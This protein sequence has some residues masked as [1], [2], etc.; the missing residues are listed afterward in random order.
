MFASLLFLL[1]LQGP[2]DLQVEP[3]AVIAP[4]LIVPAGTVIPVELINRIST[5]NIE[6]GDNVYART[7][8]PITVR[9]QIVIPVG[10]NVLGKIVQVE[11]PGRVKGKASLALTFQ[12]L[13]F[14]NGFNVP[15]YGSLGG[16]DTGN[17]RGESTLEGDSSKGKD[18]GTVAQA[19]APGAIVGGI[20]NGRKGAL[21]G[22]GVGAGVALAGVLLTRGDD[23]D[24]PRG[25]M[26]EIVL[27]EAVEP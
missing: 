5:K 1:L 14:P 12:T 18:A 16:S 9:N 2:R 10:T 15:I 17:R 22:G 20:V 21:I 13:I 25:T 3:Q 24:L 6:V 23:L 27:D 8:F 4:P 11:R 19:G 7:I 26:I